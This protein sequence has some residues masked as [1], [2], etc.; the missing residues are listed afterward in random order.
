MCFDLELEIL[1]KDPNA[2]KPKSSVLS[3]LGTFK[4][5]GGIKSKENVE[6]KT[7]RELKQKQLYEK[8]QKSNI[9]NPNCD[10]ELTINL[11]QVQI[12]ANINNWE[13]D[14]ENMPVSIIAD[15]PTY[16]DTVIVKDP[17]FNPKEMHLANK[18]L[19]TE[20]IVR[21]YNNESVFLNERFNANRFAIEIDGEIY[22]LNNKSENDLIVKIKH[23]EKCFNLIKSDPSTASK[24][25]VNYWPNIYMLSKQAFMKFQGKNQDEIKNNDGIEMPTILPFERWYL[26]YWMP[27]NES[28]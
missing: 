10:K 13:F 7:R 9:T 14:D 25:E 5:I 15:E 24:I 3:L 21:K 8:F 16:I 2:N 11:T 23:I 19:L 18:K 4:T 6:E 1:L 26:K 17:D 20:F 27:R 22:K 12:V 28:S